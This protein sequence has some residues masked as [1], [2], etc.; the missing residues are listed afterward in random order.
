MIHCITPISQRVAEQ[1]MNLY[2]QRRRSVANIDEHVHSLFPIDADLLKIREE[3]LEKSPTAG[4]AENEM[5]ATNE[6]RDTLSSS[7]QTTQG[8]EENQ[9]TFAFYK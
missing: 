7:Q 1:Q 5:N 9:E 6:R 2:S 3:F 8:T 4:I